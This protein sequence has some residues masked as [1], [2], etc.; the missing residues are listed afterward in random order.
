MFTT[1]YPLSVAASCHEDYIALVVELG[2]NGSGSGVGSASA[3]DC[4]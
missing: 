3:V 1:N 2:R 4:V